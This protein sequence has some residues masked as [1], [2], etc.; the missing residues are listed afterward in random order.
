MQATRG[1]KE[2]KGTRGIRLLMNFFLWA[3]ASP[4]SPWSPWSPVFK[5]PAILGHPIVLDFPL[6]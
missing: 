5:A 4:L 3:G 6:D 1:T 2:I